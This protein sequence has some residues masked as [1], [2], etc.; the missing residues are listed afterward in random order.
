MKQLIVLLA[1]TP[2]LLSS[3]TAVSPETQ[4]THE[5]ANHTHL[6]AKPKRPNH[7][8][9]TA[10]AEQLAS[11]IS[12]NEK[13]WRDYEANIPS[14][15]K[16][17][18]GVTPDDY[19]QTMGCIK[20]AQIASELARSA[21]TTILGLGSPPPELTVLVARTVKAL[22]PLSESNAARFCQDAISNPC[23]RAVDQ[24]DLAATTLVDVL[25][26]WE[27]YKQPK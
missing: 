22:Q 5:P 16:A 10:A 17:A 14:C 3:C 21:T 20:K 12:S 6:N 15:N 2:L 13:A 9:S 19:I 23:A 25:D 18:E 11:V 8:R 26:Q 7:P 24:I 27:P 1:I 4:P